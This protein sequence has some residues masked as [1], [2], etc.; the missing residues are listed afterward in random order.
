[1]V[2]RGVPIF[3]NNPFATLAA[4][5]PPVL[6]LQ[7]MCC[8]QI[9]KKLGFFRTNIQIMIRYFHFWLEIVKGLLNIEIL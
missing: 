8:F 2:S 5:P 3:L 4:L 1:M 9:E 7:K 6:L